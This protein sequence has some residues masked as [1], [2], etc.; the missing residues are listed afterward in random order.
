MDIGYIYILKRYGT[1]EYTFK[2]GKT[3]NKQSTQTEYERSGL[4]NMDWC[5][6]RL[7][8]MDDAEKLILN[9]FAPYRTQKPL[10][11]H[12]TEEITMDIN[13]LKIVIEWCVNNIYRFDISNTNRCT[14]INTIE[15]NRLNLPYLMWTELCEKMI[16][17]LGMCYPVPMLIDYGN[18]TCDYSYYLNSADF[19]NALKNHF[20]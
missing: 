17:D 15:K 8:H 10:S 6:V 5:P 7:G 19:D 11:Y 20:G 18:N 2:V 9:I 13:V 4:V 1:S 12:L 3:K 14:S 16:S